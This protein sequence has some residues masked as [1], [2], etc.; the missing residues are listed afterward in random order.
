MNTSSPTFVLLLK[1]KGLSCAES[2]VLNRNDKSLSSDIA[3]TVMLTY[4]GNRASTT[5]NIERL[6][7]NK[8]Q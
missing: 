3:P 1:S 5:V 6:E 7:I 2:G 4:Q 8:P